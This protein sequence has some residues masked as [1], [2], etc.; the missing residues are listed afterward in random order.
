MPCPLAR[1]LLRKGQNDRAQLVMRRIYAHATA[2]DIQ[3]KVRVPP[4]TVLQ[5][6]S[7]LPLLSGQS[8]SCQC[9]AEHQNRELYNGLPALI[10]RFC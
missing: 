3:L 6:S 5:R 9:P 1:V 2:E 8:S 4:L 7:L 10:H